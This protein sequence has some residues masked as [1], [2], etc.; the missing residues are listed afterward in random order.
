M[1]MNK[2][3][4]QRDI[5][6]KIELG[7]MS[8]SIEMCKRML[9]AQDMQSGYFIYPLLAHAYLVTGDYENSQYYLEIGL[10]L[11][12][13]EKNIKVEI[14][15][16]LLQCIWEQI[17]V[18][19]LE[20]ANAIQAQTI[21]LAESTGDDA[22]IAI[23]YRRQSSL[24]LQQDNVVEAER[25]IEKAVAVI[26]DKEAILEGIRGDVNLTY[27]WVT[28]NKGEVDAAYQMIEAFMSGG[29]TRL[30][31]HQAVA[32]TYLGMIERGKGHLEEAEEYFE[33]AL[34]IYSATGNKVEQ[35]SAC[36]RLSECYEKKK[37][38]SKALELYKQYIEIRLKLSKGPRNQ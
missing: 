18:R 17:L 3:R 26:K 11:A 33:K 29:K 38:Y 21:P 27:A 28:Y 20:K 13:A 14:A 5:H 34:A 4:I 25:Y 16:Y 1:E 24:C 12:K 10:A 30:P 32:C 23:S 36:R 8:E 7:E 9:A 6:Q 19:D 22:L 15:C 35:A 37:Q 31:R 2:D